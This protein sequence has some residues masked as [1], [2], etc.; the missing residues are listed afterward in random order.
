[1][2]ASTAIQVR[3]SMRAPFAGAPGGACGDA[4]GLVIVVD[5]VLPC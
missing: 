3:A 4:S 1:M 5:M 2:P